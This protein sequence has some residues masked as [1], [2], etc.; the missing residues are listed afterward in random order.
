[1]IKKK[2][3]TVGIIPKSNKKSIPIAHNYMTAHCPG[4]VH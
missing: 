3:N 1:M 2:Y 4:L